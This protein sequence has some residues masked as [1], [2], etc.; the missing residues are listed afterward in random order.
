M[1]QRTRLVINAGNL[2]ELV[3]AGCA[4]Y[5]VARLAGLG[6]AL[7]L[8]GVLL[9]VAAEL[10]YDSHVWRVPLPLRPQPRVRLRERRQ[11]VEVWWARRTAG[12]VR[13][14]ARRVS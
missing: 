3:G 1:R 6:F 10:I 11:S 2:L 9:V 7:V 8:A 12:L 5:G 13:W 14:R 4:V